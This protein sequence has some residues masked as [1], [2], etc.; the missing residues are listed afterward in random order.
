MTFLPFI[1]YLLALGWYGVG[2]LLAGTGP[3]CPVWRD[4]AVGYRERGAERFS[5]VLHG[6]QDNLHQT[7]VRKSV[8]IKH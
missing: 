5:G 2:Q 7:L 6:S 8:C 4:E 1:S 3:E